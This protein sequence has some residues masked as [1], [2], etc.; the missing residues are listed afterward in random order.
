[1]L[2]IQEMLSECAVYR[3][4]VWIQEICCKVAKVSAIVFI[5]LNVE[6]LVHRSM[7]G[8]P[9]KLLLTEVEENM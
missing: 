9:E 4:H 2:V 3:L 6:E 5:N 8:L 1:M 7:C